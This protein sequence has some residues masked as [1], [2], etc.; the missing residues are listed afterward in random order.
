ME[1]VELVVG[2]RRIVRLNGMGSSGF[3]WSATV[4]NPAIV[5]VERISLR[6]PAAPRAG[7][8]SRDEEFALIGLA[9]GETTVHFV[10]ARSFEPG[11]PP[12][13]SEDVFVRVSR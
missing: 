11:K 8:Y 7:T 6:K 4:E 12:Y 2:G 10:Q 1:P 3:R 13:A 9:A 5:S